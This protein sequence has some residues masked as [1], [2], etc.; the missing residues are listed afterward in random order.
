VHPADETVGQVAGRPT[1]V[2]LGKLLDGLRLERGQVPRQR[3]P[4]TPEPTQQPQLRR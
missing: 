3:R 4:V 2:E 1:P